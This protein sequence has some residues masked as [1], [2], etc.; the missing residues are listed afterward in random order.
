MELSGYGE[1]DLSEYRTISQGLLGAL[2]LGTVDPGDVFL[3]VCN[4]STR[5]AQLRPGET[6]NKILSVEFCEIEGT[7]RVRAVT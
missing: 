2:G 1:T 7:F 6:I 5:A 4:G 3:C